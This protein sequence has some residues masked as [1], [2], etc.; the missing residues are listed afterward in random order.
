MIRGWLALVLLGCASAAPVPPTAV[1]VDEGPQVAVALRLMEAAPNPG[2]TPATD[3]ALVL[4][5]EEGRRELRQLGRF[6]G[7]CTH[8]APDDALLQVRCWWAGAGTLL[9]LVR[10]GDALLVGRVA[11]DEM[12][13]S[14]A[15]EPVERVAL[16]E[17]AQLRL[18]GP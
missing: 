13:G 7:V 1:S 4:I 5:F 18:I 3:A 9:R 11:L 2:E 16:P 15:F 10:D 14:S 8:E 6:E 12:T 17:R